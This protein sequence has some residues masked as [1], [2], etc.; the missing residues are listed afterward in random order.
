MNTLSDELARLGTV[1]GASVS[2]GLAHLL[3]ND[4]TPF[5]RLVI[6]LDTDN[7]TIR[8]LLAKG[9]RVELRPKVPGAAEFEWAK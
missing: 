1:A 2:R 5:S 7:A 9:V 6:N 4:G 3:R 8:E